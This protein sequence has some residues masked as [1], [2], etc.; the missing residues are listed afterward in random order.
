MSKFE[1]MEAEKAYKKELSRKWKKRLDTALDKFEAKEDKTEDELFE[2]YWNEAIIGKLAPENREEM[3]ARID[4]EKEVWEPG[5]DDPELY[6]RIFVSIQH[7]DVVADKNLTMVLGGFGSGAFFRSLQ[8]I[9]K[10]FPTMFKRDEFGRMDYKPWLKRF[11]DRI[12]KEL[13]RLGDSLPEK[14]LEPGSEGEFQE[15][16][17]SIRLP[18]HSG[19]YE[20]TAKNFADHMRLFDAVE[21]VTGKGGVFVPLSMLDIEKFKNPEPPKTFSYEKKISSKRDAWETLREVK[22]QMSKAH[23]PFDDRVF[24]KDFW[25]V[26]RASGNEENGTF[27]LEFKDGKLDITFK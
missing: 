14:K 6:K 13:K 10:H 3:Q 8:L 11:Y 18:G 2:I 9:F 21:K 16:P 27:K 1:S 20:L 25:E 7:A 26:L 24:I 15:I 4:L 12:D 22:K 5:R 19:L 23:V 17:V